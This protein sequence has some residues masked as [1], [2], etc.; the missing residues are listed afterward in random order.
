MDLKNI[1]N[2][3]IEK[4]GLEI[5][6]GAIKLARDLGV[7]IIQL[8]GYDVYYEES[9]SKTKEKFIQNIGKAVSMA[10]KY[11]VILGFETMETEFMNT[12]SKSLEYI[13]KFPSPYLKIYPDC[14]NLMNASVLYSTDMYMDM[15]KGVGNI[16]AV[17]LKETVPNKYRE[18]EFGKGHVDFEKVID[19]SWKLGV[20]SFVT[21]MWYTGNQNW[22]LN[23]Q[24][25][26]NMM[27]KI[28]NNM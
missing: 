11:G 19:V 15:E 6:E 9:S 28:L 5:M 1:N 25:A 8:A 2:E 12:I 4:K 7:R 17:H 22:L 26:F 3:Y 24:E 16:V 18:I 23:I 10:S 13:D 27:T 20:R 14:G 21:E